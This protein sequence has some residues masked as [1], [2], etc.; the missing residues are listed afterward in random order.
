[1]KEASFRIAEKDDMVI[2]MEMIR[3]FYLEDHHDYQESRIRRALEEIL[4]N[5]DL[6]LV[7]LI[8]S[9][10]DVAGYFIISFGWSLEYF[11]RDIFID[12][13]FIREDF[14]RL[15]FGKRSLDFIE[16]YVRVNKFNAIHLEVNKFNI[17]R[18]LYES[19][20]YI[21]HNSDLMSKRF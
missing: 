2:L 11:G 12:E 14:R 1:M 6:A 9:D 21:S 4:V 5:R 17:A 3:S 8:E 13:L 18:K 15:G 19:K 7:F 16:Q 10:G 20:G